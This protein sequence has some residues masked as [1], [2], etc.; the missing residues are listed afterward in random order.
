MSAHSD[1]LFRLGC[2]LRNSGVATQPAGS[3]IVSRKLT[4]SEVFFHA[5]IA[6]RREVIRTEQWATSWT[7]DAQLQ[8]LFP[9]RFV[10]ADISLNANLG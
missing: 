8:E 4:E 2:Q 9:A 6:R 7:V 1:L 3:S 10:F 5:V